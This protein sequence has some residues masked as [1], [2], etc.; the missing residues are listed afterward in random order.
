MN[1]K[2]IYKELIKDL[3]PLIENENNVIGILSNVSSL[4]K[5]RLNFWW[6]GFYLVSHTRSNKENG[7]LLLG[8][9]Q[10]PIACYRIGYGKGVCGTSWKNNQTIIV[11]NVEEFPG[12][13]ACSS[14]SKSEIVVPIIGEDSEVLG[15]L[16]IDSEFLATFDIVDKEYLEK[17]ATILSPIIRNNNPMK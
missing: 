14:L 8:P 16:D 15:V 10:G 11:D 4:I 12:H 1:K 6:V 9:F 3:S 2:E 17:V 7:E 5:E 13:I